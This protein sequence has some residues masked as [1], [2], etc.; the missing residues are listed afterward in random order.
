MGRPWW[1]EGVRPEKDAGSA[2]G[3]YACQAQDFRFFLKTI[4]YHEKFLKREKQICN[5]RYPKRGE[6]G[7]LKR[8]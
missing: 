4:Q 5:Y 6:G 2:D 1:R 7:D 8:S 3:G